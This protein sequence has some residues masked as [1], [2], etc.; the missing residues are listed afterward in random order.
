MYYFSKKLLV[1]FDEVIGLVK[2]FLVKEGMGIMI[3]MN[4]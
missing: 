4:L 1:G 3:E 2:D